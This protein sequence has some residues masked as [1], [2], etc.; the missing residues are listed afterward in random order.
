MS[1]CIF[2]THTHVYIYIYIYIFGHPP[3]GH[4]SLLHTWGRRRVS[5][6]LRV[7]SLPS[8][9]RGALKVCDVR[10]SRAALARQAYRFLFPPGRAGGKSLKQKNK[11]VVGL[12]ICL[13]FFK[14]QKQQKNKRSNPQ[15]PFFFSRN[16][17]RPGPGGTKNGRLVWPVQPCKA[18]SSR[19]LP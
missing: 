15:P 5:A 9:L 12:A 19:Q 10:M 13:V 2:K 7:H 6:T 17:P 14:K 8:R 4:P 18:A 3:Q 11:S 1:P 16:L